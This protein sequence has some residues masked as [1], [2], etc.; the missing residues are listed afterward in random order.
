MPTI[1]LDENIDGYAEYLSRFMFAAERTDISSLVGVSIA[2]F[3][4]VGLAKGGPDEQVWDF[5]QQHG[6]FLLTDNRND[7]RPD[8]LESMIRTRTVPTSHPVFTISDINRFR[9]EREYI[10]LLAAKLLEYLFDAEN[11]RGAG[12][13]YLP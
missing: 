11:I 5:C 10:E 8:S 3:D 6:F 4:Q 12:R 1:L 2:T 13:L 9:S 7:D